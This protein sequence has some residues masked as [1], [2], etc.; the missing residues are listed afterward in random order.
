[1]L[2][3]LLS[4]GADIDHKIRVNGYRNMYNNERAEKTSLHYA[5]IK[6]L[7]KIGEILISYGADINA[8]D[9]S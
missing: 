4:K 1:M 5:A 7:K 6:N 9:F 8:L 3:L 2:E